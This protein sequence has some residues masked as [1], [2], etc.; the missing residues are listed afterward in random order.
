MTDKWN[1]LREWL[2]SDGAAWTQWAAMGSIASDIADD[3]LA[4]FGIKATASARARLRR[5][6]DAVTFG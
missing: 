3:V 5:E 2:K 1:D 4:K 6:V